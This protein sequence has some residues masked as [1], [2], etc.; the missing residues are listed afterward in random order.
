MSVCW[1]LTPVRMLDLCEFQ[2]QDVYLSPR[3]ATFIA[4]KQEQEYVLG[5]YHTSLDGLLMDFLE[6]QGR[7]E[8]L[9]I[10]SSSVVTLIWD[11]IIHKLNQAYRAHREPPIH[12]RSCTPNFDT[13]KEERGETHTA[14]D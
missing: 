8:D 13:K 1:L 3:A 2:F 7:F 12:Y 5:F 4:W 10:C 14:T 11:T 9:S 6:D